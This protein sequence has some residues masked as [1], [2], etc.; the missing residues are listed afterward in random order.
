MSQGLLENNHLMKSVNQRVPIQAKYRTEMA[1]DIITDRNKIQIYPLNGRDFGSGVGTQSG[2]NQI[3]NFRLKSDDFIDGNTVRLQFKYQIS[4]AGTAGATGTVIAYR[5]ST[6]YNVILHDDQMHSII[7]NM[8]I[9]INSQNL[10]N[11]DNYGSHVNMLTYASTPPEYYKKVL[12]ATEGAYR[13]VEDSL[14]N[15]NSAFNTTTYEGRRSVEG[16]YVSIP[17]HCGLFRQTSFLP[18]NLPID[19]QLQLDDVN[20]CCR[21]L[22]AGSTATGVL[23]TVPTNYA[24]NVSEVQLSYDAVRLH[25]AY[26]ARF[27]QEVASSGVPIELDTYQN[28]DVTLQNSA[29]NTLILSRGV[30]R[31]RSIYAVIQKSAPADL[32]DGSQSKFLSAGGLQ[33]LYF[34]INGRYYPNNN[35]YQNTAMAY[36]GL[37]EAMGQMG[38]YDA[39]NMLTWNRYN[40]N[41][42]GSVDGDMGDMF[43]VGQNFQKSFSA[44]SSGLDSASMGGIVN[45]YLKS[46]NTGGALGGKVFRSYLHF[47]KAITLQSGGVSISE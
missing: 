22:R 21:A 28:I 16:Y 4:G 10:E 3:I 23:Y 38:D 1:E 41:E 25:E 11:I 40:N 39:R 30:S 24:Y 19:I 29:V 43:I 9:S 37:L 2:K 17:L 36:D 35:G 27:Q 7:R 5:N 33:Q 14:P 45:V 47:D 34:Q 6:N 44:R 32:D 18:P 15:N 46:A 26:Y 12:S 13:Y 31:L 42:Y 8:K 20:K